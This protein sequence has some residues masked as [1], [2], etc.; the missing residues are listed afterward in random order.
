MLTFL[1]MW[2]F[3]WGPC[4]ALGLSGNSHEKMRSC[5]GTV[6]TY[7]SLKKIFFQGVLCVIQNKIAVA[8][9]FAQKRK[10]NTTHSPLHAALSSPRI[11]RRK[12]LQY[13]KMKLL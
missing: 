8:L 9:F 11:D 13:F 6:Q 3:L 10:P 12:K 1:A 7:S 5:L 2:C 4:S